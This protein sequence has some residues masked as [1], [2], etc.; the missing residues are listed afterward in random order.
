MAA[1]ALRGV[2]LEEG[3]EVVDLL[4]DSLG[5]EEVLGGLGGG[6]VV[7]DLV[8]EGVDLALEEVED[9]VAD[10]LDDGGREDAGLEDPGD[11]GVGGDLEYSRM[12]YLLSRHIEA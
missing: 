12:T 9:L 1:E 11:V 6:V 8:E 2:G 5:L 4:A 7:G 3:D 10:L